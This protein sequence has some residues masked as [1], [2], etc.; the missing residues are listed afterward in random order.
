MIGYL[1]GKLLRKDLEQVVILAGGVGYQVSVPLTT[2]RTMPP[3]GETISLEISTQVSQDAIR[4]YGFAT[5][6]DRKVFEMLI[7]V[8]KIGPR[9]ALAILSSLD[10]QQVLMALAREDRKRLQA[11]PGVGRRTVDRIMMECRQAAARLAE[12][13]G[14]VPEEPVFPAEEPI[15]RDVVSALINLGISRAEA[16]QAVT[17]AAADIG[18]QADMEALIK[19]ALR[20]LRRPERGTT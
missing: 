10:G 15:V 5:M 18:L 9:I 7:R 1:E 19:R 4:L 3:V 16:Y 2:F 8:S 6:T 14:L 12:D 13:Q 20:S 17:V 11:I